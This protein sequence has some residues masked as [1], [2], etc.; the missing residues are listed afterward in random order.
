M[1]VRYAMIFLSL[2]IFVLT[3]SGGKNANLTTVSTTMLTISNGFVPQSLA[4]SSTQ[5]SSQI[6]AAE[7]GPCT[8]VEGG[9]IGCQPV[10]LRLYINLSKT[11]FN[12]S[13]QAIAEVSTYLGD[14]KGGSGSVQDG[15]ITFYYNKTSGSKY[16]VL[17]KNAQGAAFMYITVSENNYT[18]KMDFGNL[19]QEM[20]DQG[21][22]SPSGSK[23]EM[24]FSYTAETAWNLTATMAGMACQADDVS[25]PGTLRLMISRSG[26]L[27]K[28]KAMMYNPRFNQNSCDVTPTDETGMCIY[29]DYVADD[30]AGKANVFVMHPTVAD[31]N[32]ITDASYGIST[33][34]TT[35]PSVCNSQSLKNPFCNPTQTMIGLWDN[36]CTDNSSAVSESAFGAA[37]E[38]TTPRVLSEFGI[39]LPDG[40]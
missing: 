17:G 13:R 33:L 4:Y 3:C 19:P 38:W 26:S 22:S 18:V 39:S 6:H 30:V 11:L 14:L 40:L 28:G 31:V 34:C 21:D 20:Q 15:S 25:A 29:T 36:T 2:G 27:W 37:T 32:E 8:G 23:F 24:A 9:F 1:K 10:L 35:S 12:S 7:S 16:S 5:G